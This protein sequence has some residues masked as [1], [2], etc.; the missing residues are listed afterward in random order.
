MIVQTQNALFAAFYSGVLQDKTM[1]EESLIISLDNKKEYRL[2][3]FRNYPNKDPKDQRVIK[4]MIY[5]KYYIIFGNAE[6]RIKVG[7]NKV[8]S[9]F[10]ISNSFFNHKNDKIFDLLG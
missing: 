7:E 9:N 1:I 2:N 10:G 5:D 6:I 3:N 8:F 4:G